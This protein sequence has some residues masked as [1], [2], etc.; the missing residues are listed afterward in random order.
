MELKAGARLKSVACETQ[1][2]VVPLVEN[3]TPTPWATA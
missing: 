3:L 2:I 1:V